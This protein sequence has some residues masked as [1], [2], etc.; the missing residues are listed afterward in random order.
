MEK[1]K[2]KT[3]TIQNKSK[4]GDKRTN[5][6]EMTYRVEATTGLGLGTVSFFSLDNYI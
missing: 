6:P 3:N 5:D 2:V 4:T 1:Q